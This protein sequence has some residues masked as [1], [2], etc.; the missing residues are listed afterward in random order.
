MLLSV[1]LL[2]AGGCAEVTWWEASGSWSG[3]VTLPGETATQ[4]TSGLSDPEPG[5]TERRIR[6]CEL[7][8]VVLGMTFVPIE[9]GLPAAIEVRTADALC[10][11]GRTQITGGAVM[12]WNNPGSDENVLSAIRSDAWTVTGEIDITRYENQRLPDLDAGDTAETEHIE[13]TLSLTATDEAG[14]VIR[15]ENATF[16]LTVQ[17]SRVK[18]TIS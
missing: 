2:L 8:T 16:H 6:L 15:I 12:I 11:E 10:R 5:Q 7:G 4:R 13:G 17:A 18:L 9:R 3:T 1:G 14:A